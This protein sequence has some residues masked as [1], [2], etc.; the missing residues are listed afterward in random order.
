MTMDMTDTP[1]LCDRQSE[2]C[3]CGNRGQSH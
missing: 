1:P 2:D 3:V